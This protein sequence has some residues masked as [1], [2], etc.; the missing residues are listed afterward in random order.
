VNSGK[1][2]VLECGG[3][4][5]GYI[6]TNGSVQLIY[7][8]AGSGAAIS[9]NDGAFTGSGM[10]CCTLLGPSS[11]GSTVGVICGITS[12]LNGN[13]ANGVCYGHYFENDDISGFGVGV[14]LGG[15]LSCANMFQSMSIHDNT[16]D[17]NLTSAAGNVCSGQP[18][19]PGNEL[20][21]FVGGILSEQSAEV[22]N[23]VDTSQSLGGPYDVEFVAVSL[24]GCGINMT[25]AGQRFRL[26]GSHLENPVAASTTDF[27]TLGSSC[28]GCD[29]ELHGTDI[30]E[31]KPS[32][33]RSEFISVN[34]AGGP[35]SAALVFIYGGRFFAGKGE[36]VPQLVNV[37]AGSNWVSVINTDKAN[38]TN[39]VSGAYTYNSI[40][41]G[42]LTLGGAGQA[43]LP[44]IAFTSFPSASNGSILFCNNCKNVLDDSA[45]A[46]AACATSGTAHG[47]FAKRE[48]SRWDCN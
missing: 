5:N 43:T 34:N 20:N 21:K 2:I 13:T 44:S 3:S 10:R 41:A 16:K 40:E 35:G 42:T 30:I 28:A 22:S 19:V 9:F 1:P 29:L 14:Q 36:T 27:V 24:D 46:G 37:T 15:Y 6:P 45:T 39:D 11:T 25:G 26:L 33:G 23:C 48:N 17:L 47:A 12:G 32:T 7:T 38:I 31:T 18:C 4:A 8:G